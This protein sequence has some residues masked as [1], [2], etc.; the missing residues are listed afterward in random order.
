MVALAT[1]FTGPTNEGLGPGISLG[2]KFHVAVILGY[3]SQAVV[4]GLFD[5]LKMAGEEILATTGH[6]GIRI[7]LQ[8]QPKHPLLQ[9]ALKDCSQSSPRDVLS[10]ML[11]RQLEGPS[12]D[13]LPRFALLVFFSPS[14]GPLLDLL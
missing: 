14:T 11:G 10:S 4:P 5:L 8:C 12:K 7:V 3:T 13:E 2:S 1:M 6:G 9:A